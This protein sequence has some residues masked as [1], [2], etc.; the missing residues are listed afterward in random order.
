MTSLAELRRG[1]LEPTFS[2]ER[3]LGSWAIVLAGR[4]AAR[5]VLQSASAAAR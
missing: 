5:L 3:A 4:I 2:G 1:A